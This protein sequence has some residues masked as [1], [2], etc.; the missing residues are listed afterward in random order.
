MACHN[1]VNNATVYFIEIDFFA[2]TA[3]VTVYDLFSI[4]FCK[5]IYIGTY[6]TRIYFTYRI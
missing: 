1:H 6:N 5:V 2:Q 4:A 3:T